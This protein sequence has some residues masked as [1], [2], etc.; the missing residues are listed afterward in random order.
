MRFPKIQ[1]FSRSFLQVFSTPLSI[2]DFRYEE[3]TKAIPFSH[4]TFIII[5]TKLEHWDCFKIASLLIF[6][7]YSLKGSIRSFQSNVCDTRMNTNV[8]KRCPYILS[9]FIYYFLCQNFIFLISIDVKH[10]LLLI[11]III[12][13]T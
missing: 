13:V 8:C 5:H 9:N 6:I 12:F 4:H 10:I 7:S 2:P 1:I 11:R 3:N